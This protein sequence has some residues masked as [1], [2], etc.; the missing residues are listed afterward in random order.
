MFHFMNFEIGIT[1]L[2]LYFICGIPS[3]VEDLISFNQNEW[4]SDDKWKTL[5]PSFLE[6]QVREDHKD[7]KENGIHCSTLKRFLLYNKNSTNT[8]DYPELD[9]VFI[10]WLMGQTFFPNSTNVSH[11]GWLKALEDLE[12]APHYDWGFEIL[13]EMY[14]GIGQ[15]SIGI[16]NFTGFWGILEYW[17]YTYFCVRKPILKDN[18]VDFQLWTCTTRETGQRTLVATTRFPVFSR[19]INR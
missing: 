11:I 15:A 13:G 12:K 18:T 19:G 7:L 8:T 4:V 1:P 9:R 17:W 3:G 2:D 14:R 10:L 5:L 16:P 6:S